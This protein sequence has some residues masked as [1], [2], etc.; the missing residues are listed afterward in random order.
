MRNARR[1][2]G[3]LNLQCPFVPPQRF[4][5]GQRRSRRAEKTTGWEGQQKRR[6]AGAAMPDASH[7]NEHVQETVAKRLRIQVRFLVQQRQQRQQ[8]QQQNGTESA[9]EALVG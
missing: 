9:A 7:V 4:G 8:Q 2:K 1:V 5:A 6:I 3:R